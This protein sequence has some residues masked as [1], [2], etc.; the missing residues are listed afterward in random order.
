[1]CN[2][3]DLPTVTPENGYYLLFVN[4]VL[5]QEN[6]YTVAVNQVVINDA[7]LILADTTVAT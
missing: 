1:M 4:G 2:L 3:G 7:D 5:Q 6:L